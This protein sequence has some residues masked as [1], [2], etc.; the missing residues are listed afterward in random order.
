MYQRV[1]SNNVS[2]INVLGIISYAKVFNRT[3]L[4]MLALKSNEACQPA[5]GT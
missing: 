2:T 1:S 5:A 4:R 3:Q